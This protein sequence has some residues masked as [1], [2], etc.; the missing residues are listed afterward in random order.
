[1]SESIIRVLRNVLKAASRAESVYE[2]VID[3]D[4][5]RAV[6]RSIALTDDVIQMARLN[7]TKMDN[8]DFEDASTIG[9]Y[10]YKN[11]EWL[12]SMD[13]P[14][15][16]AQRMI[17]KTKYKACAL[18]FQARFK[19]KGGTIFNEQAIFLTT[20]KHFYDPEIAKTVD[21]IG[22]VYRP[23]DETIRIY[24]LQR[25]RQ[26]FGDSFGAVISQNNGGY[27]KY[28]L[29]KLGHIVIY[30]M[31]YIPVFTWV[32]PTNFSTEF[33]IVALVTK[34]GEWNSQTAQLTVKNIERG[35]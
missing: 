34:T 10:E 15:E 1:M 8:E 24:G 3:R 33:Y 27:N 6:T 21:E 22:F 20:D 16:N 11:K 32:L 9:H 19:G 18:S 17:S 13:I 31:N 4:V 25:D 29:F 28:G 5:I 30:T 23:H 7:L 26:L 14:P 2:S 12:F 35:N